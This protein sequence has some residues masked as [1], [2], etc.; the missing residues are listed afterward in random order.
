MGRT[1][2]AVRAP[3]AWFLKRGAT[4]E[5][6]EAALLGARVRAATRR[7]KLLMLPMSSGAVLGLRFGMTGRLVV[8]GDLAIDRLEY[9]SVRVEPT[10]ERFGM[11]LSGGGSL[12]IIDAR[13]LGGVE[14]D[15][16]LDLLGPEASTATVAQ[17]RTVLGTSTAPL[18]AVLLDQHRLAGLGNLLVDETLWR[19]GLDPGRPAGS[20]TADEQRRL[21]DGIR[22]TVRTLGRRGGSHTG[23]LQAARTRGATCPRCGA[24]LLRR[25][26]GGRTT[27][28]CPVEQ[29]IG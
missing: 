26:V 22:R 14:L 21:A 16:D 23:D 27:Y 19:V 7:G 2:E 17:L 28:S 3:D 4:P 8:D 25:T 10:W 1:V 24:P 6:L 9:S 18:K 20:L 15:P 11:D 29:P 5:A 12:A 13:R